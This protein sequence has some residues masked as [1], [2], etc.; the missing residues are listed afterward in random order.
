[1]KSSMI[2]AACN[3]NRESSLKNNKL[4]VSIATPNSPV[5]ENCQSFAGV[6]GGAGCWELLWIHLT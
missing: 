1:M 4:F 5:L 3:L 6:T 2:N